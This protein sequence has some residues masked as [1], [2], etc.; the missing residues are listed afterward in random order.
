MGF[1]DIHHKGKVLTIHKAVTH[2]HFDEKTVLVTNTWDYV[3][4]WLKRKNLAKARFYWGQAESVN[5]V[6]I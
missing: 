3:D 6:A 2:P 1:R 5:I 4:L